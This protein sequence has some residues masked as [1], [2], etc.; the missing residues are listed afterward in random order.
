MTDKAFFTLTQQ[1][2]QLIFQ[3][4]N[5]GFKKELEKQ[6]DEA[7]KKAYEDVK[8]YNEEIDKCDIK[9]FK[10]KEIDTL[11]QNELEELSKYVFYIKKKKAL[12]LQIS[13]YKPLTIE[14]G[15]YFSM[16]SEGSKINI[17]EQ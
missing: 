7:L 10:G 1:G 11:E 6:S 14:T 5:E 15:V 9:L 8:K 12:E 2:L 3:G 13:Q 16:E 17:D 4:T